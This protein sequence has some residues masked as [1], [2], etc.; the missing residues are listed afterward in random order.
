MRHKLTDMYV[1]GHRFVP[2]SL[3]RP[4]C[5]CGWTTWWRPSEQRAVWAWVQHRRGFKRCKAQVWQ[6]THEGRTS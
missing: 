5:R 3:F 6:A 1:E 2:G 4:V